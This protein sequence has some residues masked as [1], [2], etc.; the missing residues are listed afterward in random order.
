M[1]HLVGEGVISGE[2]AKWNKGGTAEVERNG[3]KRPRVEYTTSDAHPLSGDPL[4]LTV[5]WYG[6]WG[7]GV[8]FLLLVPPCTRVLTST[9]SSVATPRPHCSSIRWRILVDLAYGSPSTK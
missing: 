4:V 2:W 9:V 3:K 1:L 6:I 8:L 7:P 5:W